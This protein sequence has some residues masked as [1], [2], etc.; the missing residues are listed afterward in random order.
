MRL[1][2]V[3]DYQLK[4]ADEALLVKPFRKLWNQD[5]SMSKEQFYKQMSVIYYVYSPASNYAYIMD[6]NERMKE[7]LEQEG[8]TD[9][10]PSQDFKNAVE[11]YK[12]LSKTS[13][14]ELLADTRLIIDK[15]RNTLKSVKFDPD[16][17]DVVN[18]MN[19]VTSII[20]KLPKLIKELSEA[21][22]AVAKELAE[23]GTVRGGQEL[24]VGDL[25]DEANI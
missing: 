19:T 15:L 23:Q 18:N 24:S 4:I 5:R 8:L 20:G 9:F 12:K 1:I 25:W 11:I 10:K 22:K 2:K 16:S 7:V 17:K 6:E 14:S 3:E 21:E 13:S